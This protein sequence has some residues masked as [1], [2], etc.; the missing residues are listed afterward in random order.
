MCIHTPRLTVTLLLATCALAVG[1]AQPA[2][3]RSVTGVLTEK[4]G[5][6]VDGTASRSTYEVVSPSGRV[7]LAGAQNRNWVG[8]TVTVTD[9]DEHRPGVQGDISHV[10]RQRNAEAPSAGQRTT[11]VVLVALSDFGQPITQERT[12]T[13]IFTSPTSA[14]ALFRQQSDG[15]SSLTGIVRADGDVAGPLSVGIP[16]RG[17]D[18]DAIAAAAD[19]AAAAN[20]FSP[21]SYQQIVYVLPRVPD[22]S[23]AG[24]GEL[25]GRRAWTNG[26]LETSVVAHEVGHNRGNHHASSL[27]CTGPDGRPTTLSSSCNSNEYGDPFDVMGLTPRLMS[28]FHRAQ[29]G[30]LSRGASQVATQSGIY[31][32]ASANAGSGVR[33]LLV[34]RKVPRTPV[35]EWYALERRS[36]LAPFD[37]FTI[38]DPVSTG[39][40]VRLVGALSGSDRTR[41]LDMT[42]GTDSWIDAPLLAD[43]SFSDPAL[44][45]SLRVTPDASGVQVMMPTLVDDVAPQFVG[46][47]RVLSSPGQA[48]LSWSEAT[49]DERL[50]RYEI[51]RNGS[52]VGSTTT[53]TFTDSVRGPVTVSYRVVAVDAAG[54]KTA[55]GPV[56]TTIP[57]AAT[58]GH[59]PAVGTSPAVSRP[60][61]RVVGRIRSVGRSVRRTRRGWIV[62]ARFAATNATRMTATIGGRRVASAKT[63]R[64]R[65]RFLF[66]SGASRRTVTVS[67]SNARSRRSITSTWRM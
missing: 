46:V 56:T 24:L 38:A 50:A 31:P 51:E 35:T 26:Y 43:G 16:G 41:L 32:L 37:T 47:P 23:W 49:D 53:L 8:R 62:V 42:P 33:L 59:G 3:A 12:R 61:G 64:L 6:R 30:D 14:S 18:E 36:P 1:L 19:D 34:P 65:V 29:N 2:A 5:D 66:P 22:C 54:N 67:A 7:E 21:A 44:P 28:S 13:A 60:R 27:R 10:G 17:C 63:S 39:V 40:S 4:H 9:D 55:I 15:V 52:I 11:L 57:V 48:V 45:I 20:G 25:P 58:Q